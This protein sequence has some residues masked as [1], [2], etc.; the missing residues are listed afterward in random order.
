MT[1]CLKSGAGVAAVG[2][3]LV[4]ILSALHRLDEDDAT[5]MLESE[6]DRRRVARESTMTTRGTPRGQSGRWRP[7]P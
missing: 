3:F 6:L 1:H 7:P 5:P 4:D 2:R